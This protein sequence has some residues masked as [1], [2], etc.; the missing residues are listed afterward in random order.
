[1]HTTFHQRLLGKVQAGLLILNG[2]FMVGALAGDYDRNVNNDRHPTLN[3]VETAIAADDFNLLVAALQ[4]TGLDDALANEH[5]EFTVFAPTDAAF[6]ALGSDTIKAL[7]SDPDTLS[8]ILLYHVLGDERS[9]SE[10]LHQIGQEIRTLNGDTIALSLSGDSLFINE[11]Q[12]VVADIQT[13]NGVIHVIDA[14][15]LPPAP[16]LAH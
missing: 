1:M 15:L 7:L 4:A 6:K 2:I 8:N 10:L 12:V 3:I 16:P 14:V 5:A 9:S 11:S 13:T